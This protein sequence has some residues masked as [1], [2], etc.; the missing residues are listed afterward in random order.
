MIRT[1]ITFTILFS[2]SPRVRADV[3]FFYQGQVLDDL[4]QTPITTSD[5]ICGAVTFPTPLPTNN[6]D[7]IVPVSVVLQTSEGG[8]AGFSSS[9]I[10]TNTVSWNATNGVPDEWNLQVGEVGTN[11][12]LILRDPPQEG[13]TVSLNNGT[14]LA[15]NFDSGTWSTSLPA[16]CDTNAHPA[17]VA[18]AVPEPSSLLALCLFAMLVLTFR[19][20]ARMKS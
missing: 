18:A 1:L 20:I 3:V 17:V 12:L 16:A 19:R 11:Q 4:A 7:P 15:L 8:A 13:D 6:G 2:L 5:F 9:A 10:I 14:S